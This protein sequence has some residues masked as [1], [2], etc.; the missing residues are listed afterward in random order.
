MIE[1][2]DE[3]ASVLKQGYPVRVSVPDSAGTSSSFW[4]PS[5]KARVGPPRSARRDPRESS[6][7]EP[8][9]ASSGFLD[10]GESLWMKPGEIYWV[11][12]AT[13]R[14]PSIVVSRESL[15]QGNYVVMV[16]CTTK[17][18]A[19]RSKLPNCVRFQAGEF[20]MPS[21]CVAQCEAI[22]ALEKGEIDVATGL[23][24]RLDTALLGPLSRPSATSSTRTANSTEPVAAAACDRFARLSSTEVGTL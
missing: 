8:R 17:R 7:I 2:S 24:G 15:N 22:Y 5:G 4:Q 11:D 12:L 9:P 1:L 16:L 19:I 3:Q 21:D 10:E 14:R 18:F 23:I 20:G 6:L 13:G